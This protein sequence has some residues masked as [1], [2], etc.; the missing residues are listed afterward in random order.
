M[1][2]TVF[3]NL[4][5]LIK[6]D[7]TGEINAPELPENPN[8]PCCKDESLKVLA[9][10]DSEDPLRNDVSGFLWWFNSAV[11]GATLELW[12]WNGSAYAKVD[13]LNNDDYGTFYDFAFFTND[14]NENFIGYQL[15]WQ[16]VLDA[17]GEGGYLIKCFATMAYG[18]NAELISYPYCLKTYTPYRADGTVRLEYFLNGQMGD[19]NNDR[20]FKDFGT[21]NW[22]NSFRLPGNFGF[23]KSEYKNEFL[24]Y[25]TGEEV[26]TESSQEQIYSLSL[27]FISAYLHN[28]LKTDFMQ[29]DNRFITDYNKFNPETYNQKCVIP[30][31]NYEPTWNK[32]NKLAPVTL[33]FKNG[34]N[35]FNKL[36]E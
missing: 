33:T 29:A 25:D 32:G 2:G 13:D 23:P 3:Y 34:F 1:S 12:Q 15:N 18:A 11:T 9:D 31:S 30:N 5:Y 24:R 16:D 19:V 6:E 26:W 4:F 27:K 22:Y 8:D 20:K 36:R 7:P 10:V 14:Q 35:N 17:H 28:I 21:I